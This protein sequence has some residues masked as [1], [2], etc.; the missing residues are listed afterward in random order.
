MFLGLFLLPL[1]L[2]LALEYGVCRLPKRRFWRFIPPVLSAVAAFSVAWFRWHGWSDTGEKAPV[3]TLLFV[4]GI[5]ALG[6]FLGLFLGWR[7]YKR[8]WDPRIVKGDR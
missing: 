2:S 8:L 6:V 4:P 7:L 3:E 5:T 1:L